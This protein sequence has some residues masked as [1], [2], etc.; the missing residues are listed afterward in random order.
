MPNKQ[1][2]CCKFIRHTDVPYELVRLESSTLVGSESDSES[3]SLPTFFSDKRKFGRRQ[4]ETT[5]M[6]IQN[7]PTSADE[8]KASPKNKSNIKQGRMNR[9]SQSRINPAPQNLT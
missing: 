1:D 7:D 5:A 8:S 4:G 3:V 9:A 2:V 6:N